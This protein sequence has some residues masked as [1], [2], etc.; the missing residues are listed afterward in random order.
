MF[1]VPSL[2]V[3]RLQW[4]AVGCPWSSSLCQISP[5]AYCSSSPSSY[6]CAPSQAR[7]D[8][9]CPE[10]WCEASLAGEAPEQSWIKDY[11]IIVQSNLSKSVHLKYLYQSFI[12]LGH[13]TSYSSSGKEKISI[14]TCLIWIWPCVKDSQCIVR[15]ILSTDSCKIKNL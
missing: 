11:M 7:L 15:F 9:A 13:M 4:A 1:S 14:C 6:L 10:I 12:E 3:W 8:P 2:T 5:G